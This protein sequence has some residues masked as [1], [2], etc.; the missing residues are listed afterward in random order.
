MTRQHYKQV[1]QKDFDTIKA[2][3][4]ANLSQSKIHAITGRSYSTIERI[5]K[6]KS[7]EEY[8]EMTK[9]ISRALAQ[10]HPYIP[11]AEKK[12]EDYAHKIGATA[13]QNDLLAVLRS[14]D[15]N[16]ERLAD[17]WETHPDKEAVKNRMF[18]LKHNL[19]TTRQIAK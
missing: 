17:A 2:L 5:Y 9:E 7:L 18:D 1:S 16:L 10:K 4:E 3:K 15:R 19:F 14:I 12:V 13:E 6:T 8:R 11:V